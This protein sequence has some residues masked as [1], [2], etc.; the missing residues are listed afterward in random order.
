MTAYAE[1]NPQLNL[2]VLQPQVNPLQINTGD[3]HA[4][5]L[6][7]NALGSPEK[8]AVIGISNPGGPCGTFCDP[9][10][11]PRDVALGFPANVGGGGTDFNVFHQGTSYVYNIL[12]GRK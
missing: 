2:Q 3:V 10:F 9:Y 5:Q 6:M 8:G 1:K 4:E 7:Y 11:T 12:F